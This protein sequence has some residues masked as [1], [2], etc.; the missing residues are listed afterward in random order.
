MIVVI[1]RIELFLPAVE[2]LKEKRHIVK[3]IVERI[4]VKLNA[5]VAETDLQDIWQ[6]AVIGVAIVSSEHTVVEKQ[7]DLIR[8]IVDDNGEAELVEFIVEYV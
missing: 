8:R 6:R 5:S 4:K 2:S 7:L 1:C 3:S